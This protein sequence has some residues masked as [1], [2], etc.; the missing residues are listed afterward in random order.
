[1]NTET[2]FNQKNLQFSGHET[3]PLRQLWLKKAYSA[4]IEIPKNIT[5]ESKGIFTDERAI[6]RFGV[7]KNMVS[8]IRH[9]ALACEL[10]KEDE[11]F[12]YIATPLGDLLFGEGGLDPYQ[13]HPTTAWLIHWKLAGEG[14]R[15]TTWKWLFNHVI[16]PTLDTEHLITGLQNYAKDYKHK[17]ASA[18]LKRDIECC[19]RSYVPRVAGDSPEE[20]S[21]SVLGELGLIQQIG[22]GQFEFRRGAK[23]S[24]KDGL[25]AYC[26]LSFWDKY[27][28]KTETLSFE[29]IAHEYGSPGRVFKLDEAS[30]ADRVQSLADATKGQLEWSDTAGMRQVFRKNIAINKDKLLGS[31]YD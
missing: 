9:W 22:R 30:V 17:V 27:S 29:A 26:L 18:T 31:A 14:G 23:Q 13:E 5:K 16:E 4:V 11:E 21:D 20:I 6:I 12:G 7:G 1:M 15:S 19:L 3:F 8:A 2:T 28:P 24:L 25:F 10:I